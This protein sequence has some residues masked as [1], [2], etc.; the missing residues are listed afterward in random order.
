[1]VS[2][3]DSLILLSDNLIHIASPGLHRLRSG[4]ISKLWD[5]RRCGPAPAPRPA[6]PRRR[7]ARPP[8][9]PPVAK[10]SAAAMEPARPRLCVNW[11]RG[12]LV[13]LSEKPPLETSIE[14]Y[15]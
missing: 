13:K 2:C 5:A 8:G 3:K 1:M 15:S 12:N 9:A 10:P 14:V 11:D 7:E 6:A 4:K